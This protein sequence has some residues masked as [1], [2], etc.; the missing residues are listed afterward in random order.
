MVTHLTRT[1]NGPLD[2]ARMP[3]TDTSDLPQTFVRLAWQ[4]LGT[5]ASSDT[6]E[7]VTLGDSNAVNHLVLLEDGVDLNW[8]FEQTVSKF[9]FFGRSTTV[10]LDFHQVCFLL[11]QGCL[12]NLGVCKDTDDRAVLLDTL[13]FTGDGL[14]AAL[15]VLLRVLCESLLLA[16]VPVLVEPSL[17]LIAQ[18]RGPD[19]GE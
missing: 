9:N 11:L 4:L 15:R 19:G 7:T 14:A 1:C 17:D 3:C 12:A 10:N 2:V 8:L 5:P 13:E 16:L 6:V 18:V